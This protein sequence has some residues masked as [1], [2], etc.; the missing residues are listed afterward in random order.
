MGKP[1]AYD[2]SVV[3]PL[4]DEDEIARS[5]GDGYDPDTTLNVL[6]MMSGTGD[7]FPALIGMVK[8]VFGEPDI[9]AKHREVII[10]R[11]ASVLNCP[12]EWQA[13]E[14]MARNAGLTASEIDA[15]AGDAPGELDDLDA[16]YRLLIAATDELLTSATLTD[17]TLRTLLDRFGTT[18]TRKYIATIAWFSLLSLFLN[19]TRVPME[20]TDKIGQRISPLG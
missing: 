3:V 5:I 12:Y 13:N 17:D 19:G 1:A 10:L 14:L 11:A 16:D 7:F 18:T 6:K 2:S 8:A 20:T 15:V 9:D 4:P